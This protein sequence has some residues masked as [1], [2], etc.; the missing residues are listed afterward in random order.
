MSGDKG[1]GG[2]GPAS[3]ANLGSGFDVLGLALGLYNTVELAA[4][5]QGIELT[6][7]GEGA[8]RLAREGERSLVVRA[9][10]AA[11]AH[12]GVRP[13][14]LRIHLTIA[15]PL[16]RGLG[17]SGTACLGGILRAGRPRRRPGGARGG[18]RP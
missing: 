6:G 3:T 8:E 18:P 14:G 4:I 17:S 16:R 12:L 10:H 11:F 13:P 5:P 9:A 2:G 7:A 15:I 1:V